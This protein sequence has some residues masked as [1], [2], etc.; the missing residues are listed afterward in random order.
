[1]R[2]LKVR[3]SVRRPP[4]P[5]RPG[6]THRTVVRIKRGAARFTNAANSRRR[7]ILCFARPRRHTAV[8]RIYSSKDDWPE[9]RGGP[10]DM[11]GS[12]TT[13]KQGRA[14]SRDRSHPRVWGSSIRRVAAEMQTTG[15]VIGQ[16]IDPFRTNFGA[17]GL[18]SYGFAVEA[19]IGE[20]PMRYLIGRRLA[21]ATAVTGLFVLHPDKLAG[22]H[23]W[24]TEDMTL[25][26]CDVETYIPTMKRP[27]R[28]AER[29][30]FD[31]L[32]LTDV[33]YLDLMAWR[34]PGLDS[35]PAEID[36]DMSWSR[37]RAA[38][39]SR[40]YLGPASAPGL[41]VTEI[42]D[43]ATGIVVGR[44]VARRREIFRRWEILEMGEPAMA[45][46]P[47]RIRASR[48]ENGAWMEFRRHGEPVVVPE[49]DFAAGPEHLRRTL[50][51]RLPAGAV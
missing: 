26:H 17:G 42:A 33:G 32:P 41:T 20:R 30:I 5:R 36:V 18:T 27:V 39:A 47:R 45:G 23:V 43:S 34:Y 7:R 1:M 2:G 44:A 3:V 35:V 13:G 38:A 22:T 49:D 25:R 40:C 50:E 46:L 10:Y 51:R 12:S 21:G 6:W 15:S 24:I 48:G 29:Y 14:R 37:W 31:C 16:V 28:L 19:A 11:A 9:C 4:S 8:T